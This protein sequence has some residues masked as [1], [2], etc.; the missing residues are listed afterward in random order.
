[1]ALFGLRWLAHAYG[2]VGTI[3]EENTF[4]GSPPLPGYPAH[5]TWGGFPA[6]N[7]RLREHFAA[8]GGSLPSVNVLML[9]PVESLYALAD[10]RADRAASA[11]FDLILGLVDAQYQV[12]IISTREA[13]RGSWKGE[14][15]RIGHESYEAVILPFGRVIENTLMSLLGVNTGRLICFGDLPRMDA[16]GRT[17]DHPW[18]AAAT[19]SGEA[20][21]R[22][23]RLGV[24]RPVRGPAGSWVTG[25]RTESGM[26]ATV[27]PSRYGSP[28]E[29]SVE[30]GDSRAT[31][32]RTT[33]LARIHFPLKGTPRGVRIR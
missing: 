21:E 27:V 25:A 29:G 13:E 12:D 3:G 32:P 5:S 11:V 16:R 7:D 14:D 24:K 20:L 17:I 28:V 23:A 26:I 15:F 30:F 19:T 4:L 6:W 9:F 22:L 31:L 18:G 33:G 10:G 2:P 1:M 8:T